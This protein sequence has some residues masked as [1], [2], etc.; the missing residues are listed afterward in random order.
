MIQYACT[1]TIQKLSQS[2]DDRTVN[3]QRTMLDAAQCAAQGTPGQRW[4]SGRKHT[5]QE[6]P[7]V[8]TGGCSPFEEV[9]QGDDNR[10]GVFGEDRKE[11]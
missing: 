6:W 5:L 8:C 9:E 2:A 11:R 1:G 7:W 3:R 10:A 4:F